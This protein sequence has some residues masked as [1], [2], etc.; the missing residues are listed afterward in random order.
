MNKYKF[1]IRNKRERKRAY[2]VDVKKF[3]WPGLIIY[4]PTQYTIQ[5]NYRK[6]KEI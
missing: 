6:D 5:E 4:K 1:E 2:K 3:T